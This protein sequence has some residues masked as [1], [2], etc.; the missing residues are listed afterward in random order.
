MKLFKAS[1]EY[2]HNRFEEILLRL[3]ETSDFFETR[4]IDLGIKMVR[5]LIFAKGFVPML[6]KQ[7]TWS[8]RDNA[9]RWDSTIV[10]WHDP[11]LAEKYPEPI[12]GLNLECREVVSINDNP[13]IFRGFDALTDTYYYSVYDLAPEE[14]IKQGHILV[15]TLYDILKTPT[16]N[17]V[18]GA[19]VGM[20]GKG[21][22]FCAR[23]Q[24]G[25][26]TLTVL[27]LLKGFEYVSDDYLVLSKEG[28]QLY[29]YPIYSIITLSPT[30]YNE[31]YDELDGT[32]FVSNN[33]RKDKY[34]LN[35]ANCH[36]SFRSRYP[37]KVCMF[38]EIVS[39]PEPS[40]VRIEDAMK[41]RAITQLAHS[42]MMQ[43]NDLQDNATTRKLMD[44]VR[45]EEYYQIRL[46]RD[47]HKNVEA[48][49]EFV[50]TL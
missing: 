28:D 38:P 9:E 32:R 12:Q 41:G 4:Y 19:C 29:T 42:T 3:K 20:D 7:L 44:M 23:G 49:R 48:L 34:V 37:V 47:I 24:R 43:M 26:S 27:S 50:K 35:I 36:G 45:G 22:L 17:L 1:L 8:L 40:I 11:D 25:K 31:L 2:H 10:L 33:A 39:D 15:K 13:G 46:C 5:V 14:F 6:E 18:H 16:S 30:M 21:I